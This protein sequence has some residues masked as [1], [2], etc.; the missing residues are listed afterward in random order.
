MATSNL[1]SRRPE[2]ALW[3]LVVNYQPVYSTLG[4]VFQTP[5]KGHELVQ[6]HVSLH[7]HPPVLVAK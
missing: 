1:H 7:L 6:T 2:I 5:L 4:M 3:N